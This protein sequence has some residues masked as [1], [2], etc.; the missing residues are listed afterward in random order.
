MTLSRP[1]SP[2]PATR[3]GVRPVEVAGGL[4]FQFAFREGTQE[5]HENH[6][7]EAAVERILSLF[8][9][10]FAAANLFTVEAD[11][12]AEMRSEGKLRVRRG[13]PTRR[14]PVEL[15]HNRTKRYTIPEGVPCPFLVEIGVMTA[16]GRVRADRQHKFRQINRYLE[17]VE[18]I[19]PDLPAEGPLHVVD[20]GCGKSSLTFAVHHLLT[21]IHGRE[22]RMLGLDRNP[23]VIETCRGIAGRL[24]CDG[25]EF[26]VGDI[27]QHE[28][29]E[30]V[31]LAISLHACDT[32]TDFTLAKAIGWKA[33]VI[34]AVPCCQ[35]ELAPQLR[36]DNL[37]P[38]LRHGILRE[39]FASLAT[40]ALRAACLEAAGYRTQVIEF[41]DLDHTPKNLLLRATRRRDCSE[42]ELSRQKHLAVS[43]MARMMQG[44]SIEKFTL[45]DLL[46]IHSHVPA[47]PNEVFQA[48]SGE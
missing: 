16:A 43:E 23:S 7:G 33:D 5:R 11:Y 39:R 27:A 40:D 47:E 38:L 29:T 4:Q 36:S 1:V 37:E 8:P 9:S 31:H 42:Q 45:I 14:P 10:M 22:V 21:A 30:R 34:L 26:A 48:V 17:F 41:I 32:A 20:F 44:L 2:N 24:H 28:A 46:G 3:V 6:A 13:P 25:L 19:L 15:S 35:H 12:A 18:D